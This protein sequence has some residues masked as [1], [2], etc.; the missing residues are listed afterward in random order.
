MDKSGSG[1]PSPSLD[2]CLKNVPGLIP[3]PGQTMDSR[4]QRVGTHKFFLPTLSVWIV[5]TFKIIVG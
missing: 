5:V 4:P 2:R 1:I 3:I